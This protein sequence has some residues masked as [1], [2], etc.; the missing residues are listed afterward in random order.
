MCFP[1]TQVQSSRAGGAASSSLLDTQAS[2]TGAGSARVR[3]VLDWDGTVTER[4]TLELVIERFGDIATYRRT[5]ALMGH[6]MTHDE[7][8]AVSFATVRAPLDEV[9]AWVL[10][11]VRVRRGLRQLVE[12][13]RPLVVSSGFHELIAPVLAREGADIQVLANRVEARPEGWRIAFRQRPRCSACGER[14]KRAELPPGEVA[15]IGDGYSDRCAALAAARV[16]ARGG[17]ARYLD[18]QAIPY[19]PFDDLRD[20][21]RALASSIALK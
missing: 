7:A 11:S 3:L 14:C 21:L 16:F 12:R 19:E 17:L 20:V 15:Y 8:L 18:R 13:Y 6:S 1:V 4:D 2:L 10:Q 9:V 5:G